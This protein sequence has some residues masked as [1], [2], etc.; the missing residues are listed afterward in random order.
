VIALV[1]GAGGFLGRYVTEQLIAAGHRVRSISRANYSFLNELGVEHIAGD[2]RN[3]DNVARAVSGVDTIFHTAAKAG[4]WGRWS[5]YYSINTQGTLNLLQAA[6]AANVSRFVYTSSPSVTFSGIDQVGI[7]ESIAYPTRYLCHYSHTKALAEQAVLLAN[8]PGKLH[9]CALRPHL[10]WG[11]RD[12][13]LI[14]RLIQ[15]AKSG[16][17]RQVGDGLNRVDTIYVENAAT[18]HLQAANALALPNS[19]VAGRAYFLSQGEPVNCWEWINQILAL[20][21][22]PPVKKKISY[23]MAYLA[24]AMLEAAG[25]MVGQTTEPRMTR[26]LASQ[27]ATHHWFDLSAA[28]RDFG[29]APA[30]TM[31]EG[32]LRLQQWLNKTTSTIE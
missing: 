17:L 25:Y 10:I 22:L 27:L 29:Y 6:H 4:V 3:T 28:Q 32:M 15:R 7:N 26:F 23:R 19:P 30:I 21:N 12:A 1:T 8:D 31:Q 24:G 13:H 16:K 20:V 2:I 9:T 18:A 14:P 5:E 11:P